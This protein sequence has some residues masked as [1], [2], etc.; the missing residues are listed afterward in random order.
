VS[1]VM[2]A[3][4]ENPSSFLVGP[5]NPS[6]ASKPPVASFSS[7]F[8][9]AT[10]AAQSPA[11]RT[12]N[13]P[14][15]TQSATPARAE[16]RRAP[17]ESERRAAN[18]SN[19]TDP[20]QPQAAEAQ[21]SPLPVPTVRPVTTLQQGAS[22]ADTPS[23]TSSSDDSAKTQ[24]ADAS[25]LAALSLNAQESLPASLPGTSALATSGSGP[26]PVS[27]NTGGIATTA[28]PSAETTPD[29]KLGDADEMSGTS[30]AT[31]SAPIT[32]AA[33][34]AS[35]PQ[36]IA[37]SQAAARKQPK[38]ADSPADAN[39][40]AKVS[41]SPIDNARID[42]SK[43]DGAKIEAAK[44]DS[45]K[46]ETAKTEAPKVEAVKSDA[47]STS[48]EQASSDPGKGSAS[49]G[50]GKT[51]HGSKH[52]SSTPTT[53]GLISDSKGLDSPTSPVSFGN[54]LGGQTSAADISKATSASAANATASMPASNPT[55][56]DL[57]ATDRP[58]P[59]AAADPSSVAQSAVQTAKLV[60]RAGQSELHVGFQAGEL[61][62]V[63]IRTSMIHNQLSAEISVEHSALRSLLATELPHLQEKLAAAHQITT[64][65][66]VLNQQSGGA[67]ADSR[68][69]YR[70]LAN[71]PQRSVTH[72]DQS[73]ALPG[74]MS[75]PESSIPSAQ[76]D[77]HM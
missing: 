7:E 44:I 68:Q 57:R 55:G 17:A 72:Q 48:L 25:A 23:G 28:T 32:L 35:Q 34:E 22:D 40:A 73:E 33:A 63:D 18:P 56:T 47:R 8:A 43:I 49:T 64:S 70:Q 39:H 45:T 4:G 60:E 36:A 13:A 67:S 41:Q 12:A 53:F 10:G 54:A 29:A 16:N 1:P 52:E 74:T 46:I 62:S 50:D 27:A 6:A 65:N 14:T 9:K 58:D 24:I 20:R 3:I 76:L 11:P 71:A 51:D 75:I 31:Q 21:P 38:L 5:S 2:P 37:P 66:L 26:T 19:P 61:G 59:A 30:G 15:A 69:A 77:I 42:S